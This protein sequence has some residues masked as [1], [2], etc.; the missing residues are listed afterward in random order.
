MAISFDSSTTL[1]IFTIGDMC[2]RNK[3][4]KGPISVFRFSVSTVHLM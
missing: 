2:I 3:N 1:N 4:Q